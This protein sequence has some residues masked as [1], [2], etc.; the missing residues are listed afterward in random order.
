MAGWRINSK[1]GTPEVLE[2]ET[3]FSKH[4]MAIG[5]IAKSMRTMGKGSRAILAALFALCAASAVVCYLGWTSAAGTDVS[6][7]GYAA[8]VLGVICSLAVGV[9]LMTLVFYSS[10]AGYDEPARLVQDD[11]VRGIREGDRE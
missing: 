4:S 9:S 2:E 3:L 1:H 10:R 6:R 8:L 11:D 5:S 7:A